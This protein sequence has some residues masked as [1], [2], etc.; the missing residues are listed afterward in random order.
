[1]KKTSAEHFSPDATACPRHLFDRSSNTKAV[2]SSM[3][4]FGQGVLSYGFIMWETLIASELMIK[5][6]ERCFCIVCQHVKIELLRQSVWT[7][8]KCA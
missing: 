2:P 8:W 5:N 6:S 4:D 1:V 7:H 3:V